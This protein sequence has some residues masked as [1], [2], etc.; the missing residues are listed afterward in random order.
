[1]DDGYDDRPE[2]QRWEALI[3]FTGV[4]SKGGPYDDTAFVA[5]AQYGR[6]W[7]RLESGTVAAMTDMVYGDE[8]FLHDL[9]LLAM[10]LGYT[11]DLLAGDR[12][13][14]WVHIGFTR[15]DSGPPRG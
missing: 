5:G 1:M 6:I 3:P 7:V 4:V 13:D 14:H 10:H 9:D 2:E 11:T 12:G 15:D 8:K